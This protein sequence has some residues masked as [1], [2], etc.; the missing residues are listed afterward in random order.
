M[1]TGTLQKLRELTRELRELR[2]KMRSDHERLKRIE[3][4]VHTHD[5]AFRSMKRRVSGE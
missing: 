4:K 5:D 2:E 1:E 3:E